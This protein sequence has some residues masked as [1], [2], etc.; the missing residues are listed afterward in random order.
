MRID[1]HCHTD[2]SDGVLS[3]KDRMHFIKEC[4]YPAG[5]ITDHD[6]I[7][8]SMVAEAER[9]E[10]D[11]MF[12]PGIELTSSYSGKTVHILGYFVNPDNTGLK[13]HIAATDKREK[14]VTDRMLEI[15]YRDYGIEI[16]GDDFITGSEHVNYHLML[17]KVLAGK[18]G[19]DKKK[20][21]E[22]YIGSM[23]KA[24]A[25]WM[26]FFSCTVK[27]AISLIHD[28]DGIAVLAHPG[29]EADPSMEDM[30]FLYHDESLIK[31]YISYGLDGIE[32]HCPSHSDKENK[33]YLDLCEKYNL[34]PT[35]GSDCHGNDNYL[36]PSLMDKF[37]TDFNDG[38]ER[39]VRCH[40]RRRFR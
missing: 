2:C 1:A 5:T 20:V 30:G 29:H 21:F 8:S 34:L 16:S 10:P 13:K 11:L 26:D 3:I 31:K 14:A 40:E 9:A 7:S 18:L 32:Y 38:Y 28:A 35:E 23:E 6:Y 15:L 24:G 12:V 25:G 17:V 4:G 22:C 33:F 19:F 36:G 27:E 39:M 37:K